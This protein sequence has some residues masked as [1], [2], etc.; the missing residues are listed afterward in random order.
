MRYVQ[1]RAVALVEF[2]VAETTAA[3]KLRNLDAGGSCVALSSP[4]SVLQKNPAHTHT[5]DLS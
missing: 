5:H 3:L 2:L 1:H 4:D